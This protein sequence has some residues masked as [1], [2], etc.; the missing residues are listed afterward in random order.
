MAVLSVLVVGSSQ[1]RYLDEHLDEKEFVVLHQSGTL[2][3]DVPTTFDIQQ[4]LTCFD[5]PVPVSIDPYF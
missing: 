4:H 2:V 1:C 3:Q 5:I